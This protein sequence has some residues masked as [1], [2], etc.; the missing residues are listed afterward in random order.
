MRLRRC[1]LRALK[2]YENAL[3]STQ[4]DTYIPALNTIENLV[5]P[6][7]NMGRVDEFKALYIRTRN[8]VEIVNGLD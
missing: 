1:I 5:S 7:L 3:G 8:G 4:V 2:E 6:L